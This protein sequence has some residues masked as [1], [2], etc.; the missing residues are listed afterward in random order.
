MG[1]EKNVQGNTALKY[2]SLVTLTVQNSA[3]ALS[4]RY[5]RTR[6]GDMFIASSAVVVAEF[7]KLLASLLLVYKQEGSI[8]HW[9]MTLNTQIWQQKID[10]LKV[11]VPSFIYLIQNNLL[12][13][14]ASNLD[15]ATYQVTYQMKILTTA[16]FA[17]L[18]LHKQLRGT[19][20]LSLLLLTFGVALVQLSSVDKGVTAANIGQN[21]LLGFVAAVSAC[22][23]SG[24]AGIYFE[25]I[26][27]GSDVSVWVRNV[28]LSFLSVP[29]GVMTSYA[30]DYAAITD[31][32]FFYGYDAYV[33]YLVVLNAVGGLL[34][35]MVVKYADNILKGFAT[36]LAIV[37]ST[38]ASVFLFDFVITFQFAIGTTLVIGTIFLY[39]HEP[40]KPASNPMSG[41]WALHVG[42][43]STLLADKMKEM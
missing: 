8:Q 43:P 14:S 16:M 27:K 26:L 23:C 3:V 1:T 17:V 34:V 4:M 10:T 12:Y 15:A 6:P 22:C 24:F 31:K 33:C 38:V 11:C 28:Q 20:W 18:I 5:A 2:V 35:A 30:N 29:L 41:N 39:S 40:K 19:Q 7:V 25:K 13:V 37:I 9:F 36:S 21:R 42:L 32:G